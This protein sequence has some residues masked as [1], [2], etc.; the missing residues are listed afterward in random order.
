MASSGR[1]EGHQA[2]RQDFDLLLCGIGGLEVH[3]R[4]ASDHHTHHQDE[5]ATSTKADADT[6]EHLLPR[7]R[8]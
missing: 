5:Q 7:E 8:N 6:A 4:N 1:I 3:G 2:F